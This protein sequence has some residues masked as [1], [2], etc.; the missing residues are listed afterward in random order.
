MH[1]AIGVAEQAPFYLDPIGQYEVDTFPSLIDSL[2]ST[3]G[4]LGSQSQ[5]K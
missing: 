4:R 5:N 1:V 2:D 3:V